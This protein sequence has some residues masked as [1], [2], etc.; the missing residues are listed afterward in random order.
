MIFVAT[1]SIYEIWRAA[2][3]TRNS[4]REF[5]ALV[6]DEAARTQLR[7]EIHR[8]LR[9]VQNMILSCDRL[10]REI[11]QILAARAAMYASGLMIPTNMAQLQLVFAPVHAWQWALGHVRKTLTEAHSTMRSLTM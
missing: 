7:T 9:S 11:D 4:A 5:A 10:E 1:S 6:K 3:D 8:G 2:R